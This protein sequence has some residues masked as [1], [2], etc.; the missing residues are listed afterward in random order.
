MFC[1]SLL[2][3]EDEPILTHFQTETRW[4]RRS[5]LLNHLLY[6]FVLYVDFLQGGHWTF[7]HIEFE[8]RIENSSFRS[9]CLLINL[10]SWGKTHEKRCCRNCTLMNQPSDWESK[11]LQWVHNRHVIKFHMLH[12]TIRCIPQVSTGPFLDI[13]QYIYGIHLSMFSRD[14]LLF[15]RSCWLCDACTGPFLDIIHYIYGIHLSMFSRD[16]LL[17]FRSCWLCD[18]CREIS[19]TF[20]WECLNAMNSLTRCW[21]AVFLPKLQPWCCGKKKYRVLKTQW[22]LGDISPRKL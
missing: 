5:T 1:C 16:N 13:I 3:G 11:W 17:F 22:N 21:L 12:V 8:Y 6:S 14:N 10:T 18:A 2:F 19:M 7:K 9:M 15:F 20:V 4:S